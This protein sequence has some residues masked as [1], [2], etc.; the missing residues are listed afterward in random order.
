MSASL[1]SDHFEAVLHSARAELANDHFS[2]GFGKFREAVNL[3]RGFAA[4]E[5]RAASVAVEH[6]RKW[7]PEY[8]PLAKS[9]LVEAAETHSEV[10]SARELWDTIH[11]QEQEES[12]R[13]AARLVVGALTVPIAVIQPH[14]VTEKTIPVS[15]P[16][17]V[18][19]PKAVDAVRP[20]S[21]PL[22]VCM[23]LVV[24][25]ASLFVWTH[26][27]PASVSDMA[28]STRISRPL[29]VVKVEKPL[30]ADNLAWSAVNPAD[31][32]SVERYLSQFPGGVNRPLAVKALVKYR[33]GE[34]KAH[35]ESDK[36]Q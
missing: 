1:R 23:G 30:D 18:V 10:A 33:L 19:K 27:S 20:T 5:D 24:A 32:E 11:Q 12:S 7:L 3:S 29:P 22:L 34:S 6:A 14:A 8:W 21:A 4:L 36:A 15:E 26:F 2:A 31:P 16:T 9:L 25:A 13:R 17:V 28:A 35:A